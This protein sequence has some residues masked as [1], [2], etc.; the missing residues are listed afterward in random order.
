MFNKAVEFYNGKAWKLVKRQAIDRATGP[1]GF[2]YDEISGEKIVKKGDIIVHHVVE[3]TD[4]N[5]D[6][7][8]V[9]LNLDNLRVVSFDHHNQI[10]NRFGA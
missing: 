3:L 7:F 9:S 4:E 5:V 2:V 10:H 1:D 6:D 8:S